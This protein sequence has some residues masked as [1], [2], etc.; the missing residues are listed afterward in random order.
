M[1]AHNVH[2]LAEKMAQF[3]PENHKISAAELSEMMRKA[4]NLTAQEDNREAKQPHEN[5]AIG[6]V[7][8]KKTAP[9]R[10][11]KITEAPG[12][13]NIKYVVIDGSR[14]Q[15]TGS[16]YAN[17]F[18]NDFMF[19]ANSTDEWLAQ[20]SGDTISAENTAL[21]DTNERDFTVSWEINEETRSAREAAENVWRDVFGRDPE[22]VNPDNA[23]VFSVTDT[24]H[25]TVHEIDLS[26]ETS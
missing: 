16:R 12:Y 20:K 3:Q 7:W 4:L 19:L 25:N 26:D 13:G 18:K 23:C 1:T 10:I 24:K 14:G 8:M 22:N 5:I 15:K 6:Q 9:Q 21:R 11:I 2:P 17:Y